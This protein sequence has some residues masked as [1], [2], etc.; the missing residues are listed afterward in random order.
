MREEECPFLNRGQIY[1]WMELIVVPM[2]DPGIYHAQLIVDETDRWEWTGA[3]C[4]S[5]A[6]T[7]ILSDGNSHR[8]TDPGGRSELPGARL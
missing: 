6:S 8:V 1:E 2:A 4:R 3:G 5:P 7:G